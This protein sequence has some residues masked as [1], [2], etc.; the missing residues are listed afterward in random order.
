[1]YH[2]PTMIF[3]NCLKLTCIESCAEN[4]SHESSR[5]ALLLS[6]NEELFWIYVRLS[7]VAACCMVVIVLHEF[8]AT[9]DRGGCWRLRENYCAEPPLSTKQCKH[10][11]G[12]SAHSRF[13]CGSSPACSSSHP[14][15]A[16]FHYSCYYRYPHCCSDSCNDVFRVLVAMV[17]PEL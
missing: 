4:K 13:P 14:C 12:A 1:M 7:V 2:Q 5:Q 11:S 15:S 9:H 17:V 10:V 3:P 16:S 6:V 8:K